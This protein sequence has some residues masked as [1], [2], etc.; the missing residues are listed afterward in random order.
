[1][2]LAGFVWNQRVREKRKLKIVVTRVGLNVEAGSWVEEAAGDVENALE[3]KRGQGG[4]YQDFP[5][6]WSLR[7]D[8]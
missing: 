7:G 3:K 6:A 4:L 1:L 8:V 2:G 5:L